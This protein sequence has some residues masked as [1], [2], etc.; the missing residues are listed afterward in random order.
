MKKTKRT[1]TDRMNWMENKV[2]VKKS[3]FIAYPDDLKYPKGFY[4]SS[5]QE[6][7][8]ACID[9][10]MNKEEQNQKRILETMFKIKKVVG[11]R[12]YGR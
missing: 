11:K 8:R 6:S 10:L 4:V 9:D 5:K 3:P 12:S 7:V 1:D 2:N